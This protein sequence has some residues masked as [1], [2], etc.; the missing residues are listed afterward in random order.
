MKIKLY[1]V[2]IVLFLTT[3]CGKDFLDKSPEQSVDNN[4][5]LGS[6]ENVQISLT[7]VYAG[8]QTVNYYGK[9][10]LLI[11]DVMSDDVRQSATNSNRLTLQYRYEMN[12][13]S[14]DAVG[15]WQDALDVLNRANNIILAVP[16][17]PDGT[18]PE[19]NQVLAEAK[20]LRALALFDLVR[21]Y[22]QP[23]RLNDANVAEGANGDGGHIG[24][25]VILEPL[26]P[27]ATPPRNTVKEVYDQ[28][29]IDLNE[30]VGLYDTSLEGE[31]I[32]KTRFTRTGAQALL[33][34]VYLYKGDFAK[35]EELAS[36][37]ID[38]DKYALEE[39]GNYLAMWDNLTPSTESI[40]E[41]AYTNAEQLI[42]NSLGYMYSPNGYYDMLPTTDLDDVLA[43]YSDPATDIRGQLWDTSV[44]VATKYKG[45]DATAGFENTIVIR[46]S[47]VY[48]IRAEAR[49]ENSDPNGAR[50]D[51]DFLRSK[52]SAPPSAVPNTLLIDAIIAERRLELCFEGHRLFDITRRGSDVVRTD[53]TLENGNCIVTY[54]DT[55]FAQ[56]IP[57]AELDINSNMEQNPGY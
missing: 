29:I 14:G 51:L 28:V 24:V 10:F 45:P 38:S 15:F 23:Y 6:I 34:R 35:A 54:P 18:E 57:Q 4:L 47:E 17:L 33:A 39:S 25:P 31:G 46:L 13:N 2:G 41:V 5:A 50:A 52:R 8:L 36:T 12:A 40:F 26:L 19:K 9:N 20:T 55:R 7:G 11:Q 21:Y 16:G 27:D 42:T 44:P 1:I 30:A 32:E 43:N 53:C 37:V 22:S 56:P 48:L 49:V 3:S